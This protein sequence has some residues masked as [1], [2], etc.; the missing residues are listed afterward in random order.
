MLKSV[1]QRGM[2][3]SGHAILMGS[4]ILSLLGVSG[5]L[6]MG[7]TMSLTHWLEDP[8]QFLHLQAKVLNRQ[9]QQLHADSNQDSNW[10]GTLAGFSLGYAY[11]AKIPVIG[12]MVGPVLGALLGYQLDEQVE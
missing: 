10:D 2:G 5:L 11:G 7:L 1:I 12:W 6:F 9:D 8:S 4:R 3:W